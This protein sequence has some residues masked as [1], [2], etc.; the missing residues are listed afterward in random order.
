MLQPQRQYIEVGHGMGY[1]KIEERFFQN[2]KSQKSQPQ[3][4]NNR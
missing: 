4:S 3:T 1:N 2:I